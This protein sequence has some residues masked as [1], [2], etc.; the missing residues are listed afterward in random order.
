MIKKIGIL[1]FFN[2]DNYGAVW[3][4]Y[5]LQK[6]SES[7][8]DKKKYEV[9]IIN[10]KN[11]SIQKSYRLFTSLYGAKGF[12]QIIKSLIKNI[13]YLKSIISKM[14]RF[15]N[16]RRCDFN[17]LSSNWE[18]YSVIICGSDQIWNS[19]LTKGFDPIY[20]GE[21]PSFNGKLIAYAPSNGGESLNNYSGNSYLKNFDYISVRE[22]SMIES[23]S[24]YDKMRTT[25]VLDPVFL[26]T[27]EFWD[28]KV[29]KTKKSKYILLYEIKSNPNL[30]I[31][32][33]KLA[34]IEGLEIVRL[35][36]TGMSINRKEKK[37]TY[38]KGPSPEE[39]LALIKNA[40]YVLTTSFHGTAFSIIFE[41]QFYVY[42]TD[43][44]PSRILLLL[45]KMELGKRCVDSINFDK[46]N[47]IEFEE[48]NIKLNLLRNKSLKFL[49]ESLNFVNC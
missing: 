48:V 10:Y 23:F 5:S 25:E 27:K 35:V 17:I 20:F 37:V 40:S 11:H 1:T 24:Q 18:D 38:V 42:S 44:G 19:E 41:K 36:Y 7:F 33:Q 3:Q 21:I 43:M 46:L 4:A 14:K 28:K 47:M 16:F 49:Y 13:I 2:A 26:N 12:L 45:K 6:I 29:A 32:A 8:V 22:K 30:Y 39:F 31:D 15:S 34:E 9:G